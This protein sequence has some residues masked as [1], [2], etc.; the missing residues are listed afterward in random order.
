MNG[1]IY[2][3]YSSD[4]QREE[5]IEGQIRE[6][7]EFAER[8]G[9]MVIGTYIDRAQSAK[10]DNRP[11][12]QRMVKDS[13]KRLFDMVIVWK[14][15][16]FARNR[17]DS[18]YYK[19]LLKKNNVKVLSAK[20]NISDRPE[21]ILLESMLEGYAEFYSAELSEKILRG[22]KENALKCRYNGGALPLGYTT[23]SEQHYMIDTV[24]APIVQEIF[25][26]YADGETVKEIC[27]TLNE[28]GIKTQYGNA[29]NKNS[30]HRMLKNRRYIGEYIYRDTVIPGG[31]PAI[32]PEALFERVQ[33][34][35]EKNKK[36]PAREKTEV[37]YLLTTKLYCGKCGAFMVGES[38][39]SKTGKIH[40]YYKCANVKR[41]KTCDKK[42]V[43]KDW[44]ETLVVDYTMKYALADDTIERMAD[45][46]MELQQSENVALPALRKQLKDTQ[47]GIDNMLDAIQQGII[48]GSTKKR[49]DELEAAKEKLEISILQEEMQKPLLTREQVVFW[50]SRFKKGNIKDP[51]FRSKLIDAFVNSIY[52]Y[53]DK[54]VLT[55]NYKD[56]T[57]T[58]SLSEVEDALGD[59]GLGSDL[60][61]L[62]PPTDP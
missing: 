5:S 28:R 44:I 42:T 60:E 20:E 4:N 58:V 29:F 57:K 14:L 61:A 32:I 36:A 1:V 17:Y 7:K 25:T 37:E 9:I 40:C 35:M 2:A 53:D 6:C 27:D 62:A 26:R 33:E 59:R 34:R 15:D 3:R 18:A 10:T 46:V 51:S 54:M 8:Q 38:G 52:L 50:I 47:K 56:G 16:R 39:T 30:L 48:T 45:A 49:L 22:M 11:D 31:I 43:Q 23:D 12:F 19:M 24:T 13:T 55:Y 41:A 21:G